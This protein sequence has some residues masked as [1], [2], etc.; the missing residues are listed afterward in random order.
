MSSLPESSA[1]LHPD[2][3]PLPA[4]ESKR[5]P[6]WLPVSLVAFSAVAIA[7]PLLFIRW[8]RRAALAESLNKIPVSAASQLANAPTTVPAAKLASGL[9]AFLH[10]HK[11]TDGAAAPASLD[12]TARPLPTSFRSHHDPFDDEDD[13]TSPPP[14]PDDNFNAGLY[15]AKAFGIATALVV[16]GA[17]ATVEGVKYYLDVDDTRQF[18][19]RMRLMILEKMPMLT[20]KIHRTPDDPLPDGPASSPVQEDQNWNWDDAETRLRRAF[21]TGGFASWAET[22]AKE[23]ETEDRIQ[24]RKHQETLERLQSSV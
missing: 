18:G 14:P 10:E 12:A 9:G 16:T 2:A 1:P 17:F 7:T 11:A 22:V 21:E 23:V 20:S 15:T 3:Q 6:L 5:V 19:R 8:Q 4:R 24:R 13:V